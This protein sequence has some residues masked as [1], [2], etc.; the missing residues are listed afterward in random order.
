MAEN[1]YSDD[2]PIQ[3][4]NEFADIRVRKVYTRNGER[5]EIQAPRRGYRILL[6]AVEL[7]SLT[8][9]TPETFSGFLRASVGQDADDG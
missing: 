1:Q 4:S 3:I 5:L 6:D 8:W 7:E 2:P 9:Q